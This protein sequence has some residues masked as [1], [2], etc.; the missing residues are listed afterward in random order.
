VIFFVFLKKELSLHKI[1]KMV[2]IENNSNKMSNLQ[3][4]L[5]KLYAQN[6]KDNDL[7]AIKQ[8]IAQYF[9]KKASDEMDAF[10]DTTGNSD[11]KLAEW[12][13]GHLRT[14]S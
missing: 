5:L 8:M 3:L 6:V 14:R 1:L 10:L 9:A 13:N 2:A 12:E 7:L 4:E 11:A